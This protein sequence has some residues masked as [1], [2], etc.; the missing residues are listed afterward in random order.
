MNN[1]ISPQSLQSPQSRGSKTRASKKGVAVGL[2]AGLVGGS[3]AGLML[4]MPGLSSAA[5]DDT[6]TPAAIIQQTDEPAADV[7]AEIGERLRASLQT[8]V[9][10][11]TLTAAQADSVTT[12]L[13]ENRPD[14]GD[15]G[16]RG[17]RGPGKFARSE[18]L[19]DLLGLDADDLR[20]QLRSG[21]TLAEI[22]AAN[23]VDSDTLVEALVAQAVER[24]DAAVAAERITEDQAADKLA[25]I[26][27]RIADKIN[28]D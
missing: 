16:D 12:H 14:R 13:V 11:G 9:D 19:A 8:L 28:G 4:G 17:R 23:G 5:T 1:A 24:I 21:S 7:P 18:V 27:T 6:A 3:I 15:H 22:A 25:D 10:D 20:G 2:T 26:E